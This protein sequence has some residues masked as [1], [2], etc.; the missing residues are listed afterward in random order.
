[1]FVEGSEG[2][3]SQTAGWHMSQ[4]QSNMFCQMNVC[5]KIKAYS[6]SERKPRTK[7][8]GN[9]IQILPLAGLAISA[10]LTYILHKIESQSKHQEAEHTEDSSTDG[11]ATLPPIPVRKTKVNIHSWQTWIFCEADSY[12]L[13]C[14]SFSTSVFEI[15]KQ[16][17]AT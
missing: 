9:L 13:Y 6:L 10:E 2:V 12:I 4:N 7:L 16:D 1:M 8:V 15:V 14:A 17:V 3:N 5:W 11:I